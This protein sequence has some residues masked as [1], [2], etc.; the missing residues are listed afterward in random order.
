MFKYIS[1]N[2]KLIVRISKCINEELNVINYSDYKLNISLTR[3]ELE[4]IKILI[5]E[6]EKR[7]EIDINYFKICTIDILKLLLCKGISLKIPV[8]TDHSHL[9]FHLIDDD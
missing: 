6:S 2:F 7:I 4:I 8:M 5:N 9:K 1:K 3:Q